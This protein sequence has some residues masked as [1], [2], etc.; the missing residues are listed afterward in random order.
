MGCNTW[1]GLEEG[2]GK[3]KQ[4]N[5]ILISKTFLETLSQ[6]TKKI[7]FQDHRIESSPA[8]NTKKALVL[9]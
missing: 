1:E 5:S 8:D 3:G 7:F 2:K 4:S 6:K 9:S